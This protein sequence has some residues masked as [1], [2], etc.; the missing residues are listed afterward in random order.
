MEPTLIASLVIA[1]MALQL[2][3]G[4]LLGRMI[5]IGQ[6]HPAPQPVCATQRSYRR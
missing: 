2:P 6:H 3:L 1:W 4:I 5:R